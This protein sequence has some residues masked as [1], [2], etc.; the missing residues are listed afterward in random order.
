MKANDNMVLFMNTA[1]AL[2]TLDDLLSSAVVAKRVLGEVGDNLFGLSN[3][4]VSESAKKKQSHAAM[5]D[6]RS[7]VMPLCK[8]QRPAIA[9]IFSCCMRII[10]SCLTSPSDPLSIW[11]VFHG[12][13][14]PSSYQRS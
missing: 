5:E 7:V 2:R 8:Y 13:C 6:M 9:T 14:L 10:Y 4:E 11:T 1:G 3:E 12:T